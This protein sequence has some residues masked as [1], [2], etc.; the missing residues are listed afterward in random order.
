MKKSI[1]AKSIIGKSAMDFDDSELSEMCN[2][3]SLQAEVRSTVPCSA[4]ATFVASYLGSAQ[5]KCGKD[6]KK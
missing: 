4:L 6:N 5:T 2:S 3:D 1:S